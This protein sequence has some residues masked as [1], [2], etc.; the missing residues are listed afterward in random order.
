[1][2]ELKYNL[3]SGRAAAKRSPKL[4]EAPEARKQVGRPRLEDP[5]KQGARAPG[6]REKEGGPAAAK[7]PAAWANLGPRPAAAGLKEATPRGAGGALAPAGAEAAEAAE[8]K[9]R[10]WTAEEEAAV[11]RAVEQYGEGEWVAMHNDA[12][13]PFIANSRTSGN[14]KV[15]WP[16]L[17]PSSLHHD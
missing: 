12:S 5:K 15:R 13:Y 9:A 10:F 3:G 8:R 1:M 2:A 14:I 7:L 17:L 4:P 16:S 6:A 11:R